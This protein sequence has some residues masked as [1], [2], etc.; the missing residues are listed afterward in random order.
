[1][2][3]ITSFSGKYTFLSN[4]TGDI[5]GKT[6][7]HYYQAFKTTDPTWQQRI[8]DC[9][10]P[11]QAKKLGRQAPLRKDW[12]AVRLD[13]MRQIVTRKFSVEPYKSLLLITGDAELIEGNTWGV[14]KGRGE[15]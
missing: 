2:D 5:N 14:C 10:T 12:N 4:F 9:D 15:N 13:V 11:G 8:L 1:M 6:A 3:A 7:E